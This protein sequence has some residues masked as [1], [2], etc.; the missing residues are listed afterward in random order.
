MQRTLR[1]KKMEENVMGCYDM[2]S[3]PH[4]GRKM[5]MCILSLG[6]T[7]EISDLVLEQME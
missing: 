1:G 4:N 2:L 7:K 3:I 6:V 5:I